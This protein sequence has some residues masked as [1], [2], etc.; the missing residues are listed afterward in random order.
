MGEQPV[1][2]LPD[3]AGGLVGR[4]QATRF[5]DG[6]RSHLRLAWDRAV[7]RS[8]IVDALRLGFALA[9]SALCVLRHSV[10]QGFVGAGFDVEAKFDVA[11]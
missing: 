8:Q 6:K 4:E 9:R 2:S 7:E 3:L 5:F 1:A 10:I 11:F